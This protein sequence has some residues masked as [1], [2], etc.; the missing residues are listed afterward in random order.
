MKNMYRSFGL[1]TIGLIVLMGPVFAGPQSAAPGP[2]AGIGLSA[3]ALIG[4]TY[5]VGRRLFA[6]KK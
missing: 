5:W 6:R 4:G 2:I 1:A 3:L